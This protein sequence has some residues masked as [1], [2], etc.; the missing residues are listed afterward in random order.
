MKSLHWDVDIASAYEK[1]DVYYKAHWWWLRPQSIQKEI[2]LSP[3]EASLYKAVRL[4]K[5]QKDGLQ[6]IKYMQD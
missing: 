3:H 6:G 1:I 4:E 2:Q 5:R